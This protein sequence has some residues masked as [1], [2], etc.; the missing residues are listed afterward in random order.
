MSL[1]LLSASLNFSHINLIFQNLLGIKRY[2]TWSECSLECPLKRIL[3]FQ[4]ECHH[5]NKRHYAAKE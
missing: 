5:R 2:T 3:L 1:M 4:W